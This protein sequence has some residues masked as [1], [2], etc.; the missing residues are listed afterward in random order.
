MN[1]RPRIL[2]LAASALLIAVTSGRLPAQDAPLYRDPSPNEGARVRGPLL[3]A[4]PPRPTPP[5]APSGLGPFEE[6]P[7]GASPPA[8]V[9]GP[10][11]PTGPREPLLTVTPMPPPLPALPMMPTAAGEAVEVRRTTRIRSSGGPFGR[12]HDWFR[13][14]LFGP[15]RPPVSQVITPEPESGFLG[16]IRGFRWPTWPSDSPA[17]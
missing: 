15:S 6:A 12:L 11:A 9:S 2:P 1:R 5:P 13:E 8:E 10:E 7:R 16:L 17:S 4:R 3:P 14:S